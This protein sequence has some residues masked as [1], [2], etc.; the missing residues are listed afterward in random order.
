MPRAQ[1]RRRG[2][3]LAVIA[4]VAAGCVSCASGSSD[5]APIEGASGCGSSEPGLCVVLA[6]IGGAHVHGA[7]QTRLPGAAP[8]TTCA[9][10]VRGDGGG[11][12]L[13]VASGQSVDGHTIG[14]ANRITRY[15]GP[16]TY[17]RDALGAAGGGV[18]IDID[19][20]AYQI[21][22]GGSAQAEIRPDGSGDLTFTDLAAGTSLISGSYQ[23]TC[24]G[25]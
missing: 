7:F 12:S 5:G 4:L 25:R 17:Q 2:W 15:N 13:P 11:L 3:L 14:I 20:R 9:E 24:K 19:G 22:S 23:W 10:Y 21:G 18:Q 6:V 1:T 8:I 16:G